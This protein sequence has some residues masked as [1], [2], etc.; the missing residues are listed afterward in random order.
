MSLTPF[1]AVLFHS[2]SGL[3]AE[4]FLC[5]HIFWIAIDTTKSFL[6]YNARLYQIDGA[7]V[8][9]DSFYSMEIFIQ[10]SLLRCS[11]LDRACLVSPIFED[12]CEYFAFI[13]PLISINESNNCLTNESW[14]SEDEAWKNV[15]TTMEV[16]INNKI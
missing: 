8:E 3:V 2:S 16:W 7:R 15:K 10:I 1:E 6:I 9:T 14:F 12:D 5:R 11:Q 4:K 13:S